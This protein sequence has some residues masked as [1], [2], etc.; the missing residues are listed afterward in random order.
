MT[1]STSPQKFDIIEETMPLSELVLHPINPRQIVS[2]DG[3]DDL[4]SSILASGLI[5]PLSVLPLTGDEKAAMGVVANFGV[6]AGGRRLRALKLASETN[7][8]LKDVS[9]RIAPDRET[10]VVWAASENMIR[11]DNSEADNI[12]A[13]KQMFDMGMTVKAV[14]L[15]MNVQE[16]AVRKYQAVCKLPMDCLEAFKEKSV[17]LGHLKS[18]TVSTD[19]N[20]ILEVLNLHVSGESLSEGQMK[21]KLTKNATSSNSSDF[22]FLGKETYEEHGGGY[23]CDLFGDGNDIIDNMTLFEQLLEEKKTSM[24]AQA[25]AEGFQWAQVI[26]YT[27][28]TDAKLFPVE[29]KFLKLDD[30]DDQ[31][32]LENLQKLDDDFEYDE[33]DWSRYRTLKEMRVPFYSDDVKGVSGVVFAIGFGGTVSKQV[34]VNEEHRQA[35]FSNGVL[36]KPTGSD[37]EVSNRFS[38]ALASDIA[39]TKL[40]A[41][42][43]GLMDHPELVLRLLAFGLS[44][45]SGTKNTIFGLQ[46]GRPTNTPSKLDGFAWADE[47]KAAPKSYT[48]ASKVEN[49]LEVDDLKSAFHEFETLPI[50]KIEEVIGKQLSL[51]LDSLLGGNMQSTDGLFD[52]L[53]SKVGVDPRSGWT[54]TVA[55][56]WKRLSPVRLDE[57]WDELKGAKCP[58]ELD[59]QFQAEKKSGKVSMLNELFTEVAFQKAMKL[60]DDEV[61]KINSWMPEV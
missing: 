46:L 15:S 39:A 13:Y 41:V 58:S 38:Q 55:G 8:D 6:V 22:K 9:V 43:K 30:A 3:I 36:E 50:K 11:E 37:V 49:A 4:V 56:F 20:A 48:E 61:A 26:G 60:T 10:A 7:P 35:A 57:I 45:K 59:A 52:Y 19:Q 27:E 18:M 14:A 24:V 33:I 32:E 28:R 51:T 47:L 23:V 29:K 44:E 1:T 34:Y 42:Q 25:I 16:G 40:A 21:T 53:R 31:N 5:N 54:P 17:T 2:Q 12:I